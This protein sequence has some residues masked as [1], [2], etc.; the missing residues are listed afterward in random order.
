VKAKREVRKQEWKEK[1]NSRKRGR[2][3]NTLKKEKAGRSE[4]RRKQRK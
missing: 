2:R 1:E 3:G 4:E